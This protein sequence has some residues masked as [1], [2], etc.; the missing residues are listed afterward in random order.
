MYLLSI[1]DIETDKITKTDIYYMKSS[2]KNNNIINKLLSY[3]CSKIL[4]L[5]NMST[6]L[7]E[8]LGKI[9]SFTAKNGIL[10]NYNNVSAMIIYYIMTNYTNLVEYKCLF[11]NTVF[12]Q[13]LLDNIKNN[14]Q[15]TIYKIPKIDLR[16][17]ISNI[18][19][20]NIK[21]EIIDALM[22]IGEY[23]SSDDYNRI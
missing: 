5:I 7:K 23:E 17:L 11:K 18:E 1:S 2:I 15:N 20:S 21:K 8:L 4:E 9:Q 12:I 22:S 3:D 14:H 16:K 6:T 13:R 19:E 10:T